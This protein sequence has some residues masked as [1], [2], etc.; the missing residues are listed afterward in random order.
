MFILF[1][2]PI[3]LVSLVFALSFACNLF[4]LNSYNIKT[5]AAFIATIIT[6]ILLIVGIYLSISIGHLQGFTTEQ[7]D[8]TYIFQ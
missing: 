3:Y 1:G 7:Q 6:T 2:T 4:I 8:E 5:K